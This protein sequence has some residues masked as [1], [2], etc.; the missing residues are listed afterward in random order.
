M[1]ANW[2]KLPALDS[3]DELEEPLPEGWRLDKIENLYEQLPVGKRFDQKS[4]SAKGKVPVIDQSEA[5]VIGWHDEEPGVMASDDRPVV[6][7]A[8]HTCEMRLMRRPFSV[9]QNVFPLVGRSDVCDTRFLYYGTK[10][11]VRLEEYKGHFPDYR[12]KWIPLPPLTEQRAIAHILGTLDDKIELNRRMS[13]TL[14]AMARAL[15][16]AWFVDFEP[17]R[18]KMEG[19]WQR[20]QS[21][22]GLPAHLYDLFPDR[23]VDSELGEIPEGWRVGRLGDLAQVTSGKR[24]NKVYPEP[25]PYASI[26]LW[27]GNGPIGYVTEPLYSTPI[28]L[29]GRVGTLGS[30]FRIATPCWPSDNTLVVIA[31]EKIAIEFLYFQMKRFDYDALNRGSTQPL[32]T[33]TDLNGQQVPLPSNRLLSEFHKHVSTYFAKLDESMN[34]SRT[35]A[36]LRDALLPKLISGELRVKNIEEMIRRIV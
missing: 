5:G 8:N 35:L 1:A 6:T 7:F 32:L 13:E 11:R 25:Q 3:P 26:P 15:F 16:K 20:G 33:Q 24:P 10:G 36:T 4:S 17:V 19:R 9:I 2:P 29:T 12:R 27:G 28:L 31:R 23:L 18:A 22:P 21:L 14:E 34:E 30:V